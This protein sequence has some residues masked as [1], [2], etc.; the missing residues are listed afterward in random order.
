MW[1]AATSGYVQIHSVLQLGTD[2]DESVHAIEIVGGF[3]ELVRSM[4]L[5]ADTYIHT[6]THTTTR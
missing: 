6:H 5:G 2:S 1:Y 4:S 3:H